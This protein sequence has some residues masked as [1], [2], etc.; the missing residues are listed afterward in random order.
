MFLRQQPSS[1]ITA[2]AG[3]MGVDVYSAWHD[4][5]ASG[6]E[7]GG[8]GRKALNDAAI[9]DAHISD[10][11]VDTVGGIVDCPAGYPKLLTH[12]WAVSIPART[13]VSSAA[14]TST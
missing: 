7:A 8:V 11:P 13:A 3:Q 1:V 9:L 6:I 4:H 2:G 14:R 5:H 12:T 10:L